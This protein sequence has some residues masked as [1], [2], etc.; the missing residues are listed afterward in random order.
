ML[1]IRDFRG[2]LAGAFATRIFKIISLKRIAK[3]ANASSN[4]LADYFSQ[5]RRGMARHKEDHAGSRA[6]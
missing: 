3:Q 4:I 5:L 2:R 1:L 6:R